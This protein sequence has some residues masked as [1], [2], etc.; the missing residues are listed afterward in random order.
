[1]FIFQV[2]GE[3]EEKEVGEFV[4][5]HIRFILVLVDV[6]FQDCFSGSQPLLTLS[7]TCTDAESD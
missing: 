1:M 3:K 6:S 2:V 4:K 7:G 5:A